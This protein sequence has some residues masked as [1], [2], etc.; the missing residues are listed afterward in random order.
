[1]AGRKSLRLWMG[2]EQIDV[3]LLLHIVA[4]WFGL[5]ISTLSAAPSGAKA[6]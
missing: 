6:L 3:D 5:K 4:D 1:M 2:K